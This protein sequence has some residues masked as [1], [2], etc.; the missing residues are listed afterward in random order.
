M[1]VDG[2]YSSG[3]TSS[4][5]GPEVSRR[6]T[7]CGRWLFPFKSQVG[8]TI[9]EDAIVGECRRIRGVVRDPAHAFD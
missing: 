9:S 5:P 8:K 3:A 4:D 6:C 7:A 1:V 2:F